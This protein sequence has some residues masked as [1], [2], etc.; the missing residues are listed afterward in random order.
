M[1][2]RIL[3]TGRDVV[4]LFTDSVG[5]WSN[6]NM[7]AANR[8]IERGEKLVDRS[9]EIANLEGLVDERTAMAAE[10]ISSS[11]KRVAEYSMD[12]AEIAINSAMD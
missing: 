4:T 6:R 2:D 10:L 9:K 11:V 12:I 3:T 7:E 1:D 5:T 8:C